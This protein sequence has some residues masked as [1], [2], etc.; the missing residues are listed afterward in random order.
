VAR[1]R[2]IVIA[3]SVIALVLLVFVGSVVVLWIALSRGPSIPDSATLVLRPKG[4]LQEMIPDDVV[5]QL[6]GRDAETVSSFVSALRKA[7]RDPRISHVLLM[8]SAMEVP[9]WA[10]LQELRDAIVDFRT[11]GKRVIA[12]LDYGG[13][14]EYYLA[15]AADRIFLLPTSPLDLAGVASYEVFLRGLFDKVGA[16]PDF[17]GIG[18]YKT[19]P[20]QLTEK[21]MTPAHRQMSES[22]N[23]SLYDQLVSGIATG[24]R[25]SEAE[26]R[27]LLDQGPFSPEEALRA[28]LVDDLAYEDELDD[29]VPDL[30]DHDDERRVQGH[31]Y[32]QVTA[33]SVGIKPTSRIA[34]LY[35]V[36][37]IV[38]GRSGFDPL[39]GDVIGSETLVEQIRKVRDDESIKAIVLRVDSPGGS[40]V[41]SDVI[42][43]ELMITRTANPKRPLIVSMSDLAASGGYYIA[44]AGQAIV[45]QPATLTG[46]IGIYSGK[47][48]LGGTAGKVG[49]TTE[50]VKHGA[51]ADMFSPFTPFTPPQ[52]VKLL[53]Y[54]Q[55][56]YDGFVEKAAKAR[57]TTPAKIDAVAQGRVWTGAQAKEQ[58]LVDVLGG[59]DTAVALAKEKAGI[60][61]AEDVEL[62]AYPQRRT[63]YEVLAE[64]FG[65]AQVRGWPALVGGRAD[66][67]LGAAT[68]TQRLF[69][70]GEPLAILPAMLA[71]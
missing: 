69:R 22:L 49:I 9:Y 45:A 33:A 65:G 16:T 51:N 61:A 20:N 32:Q 34:V 14:R 1:R 55:S 5:G 43:R 53:A 36:G 35:A 23:R 37:T 39:N 31:Q 47:I 21:G 41:A 19:A 2:G 26:I 64:E 18:A 10:K 30:G 28:G 11:S 57:G 60:P 6:L 17:I 66:Q 46:S 70:R 13:D 54:M 3:L 24:R 44:M 67:V 56:F 50:T 52:R 27:A 7:K 48:A 12:F 62:V 58:G 38:S 29:K 40:A 8:P 71:P 63:F 15:S 42:W 4:S 68:R 59:L 25:K